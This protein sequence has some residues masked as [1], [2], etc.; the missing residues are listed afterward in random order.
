MNRERMIPIEHIDRAILLV[1]RYGAAEDKAA[2][3]DAIN[4]LRR[5]VDHT[6]RV[7]QR[8]AIIA[9]A[10]NVRQRRAALPKA[11][12]GETES[13]ASSIAKVQRALEA[14]GIEFLRDNGVRL[15]TG[16]TGGKNA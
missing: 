1:E 5:V 14:A 8:K 2:L 16:P 3:S 13:R 11:K 15:R 7:A 10:N 4:I 6:D 9:I 12:T